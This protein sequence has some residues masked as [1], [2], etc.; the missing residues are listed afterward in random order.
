MDTFISRS[1]EETQALGEAWGRAAR[2]G[3][4]LGLSGELGAGKTQFVKGL[5]RGLGVTEPV[6]SPTFALVHE[7]AGGR[8]PLFHLDFYRLESP[9]QIVAA[10]LDQYLFAPPGVVVVEWIERWLDGAQPLPV[11]FRR[12]VFEQTGES[13]RRITY[14]D[15]GA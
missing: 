4:V 2:A 7:Y 5:A 8:A 9:R 13:E 12:V 14:E 15:S 6:R 11:R 1:P 10:G 3:W